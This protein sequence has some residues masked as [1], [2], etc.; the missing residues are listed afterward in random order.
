MN[1]TASEMADLQEEMH[2]VRMDLGDNV[3]DFFENARAL[4]DWHVYWQRHPWAFSAAASLAGYLLVPS[5]RSARLDET[6]SDQAA[7]SPTTHQTAVRAL[8]SR[9]AGVALGL[10]A[11]KGIEIVG[12]QVE[13]FIESR[14]SG[15]GPSSDGNW[16]TDQHDYE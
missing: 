15:R 12:R 8:L 9:L 10:V 14:R 13:G 7:Q 6:G 4:T 16:E 11:Q 5:R 2:R 1:P 3:Q